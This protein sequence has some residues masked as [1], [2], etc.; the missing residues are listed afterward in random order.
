MD[1]DFYLYGYMYILC[2]GT[3]ASFSYDN[4]NNIRLYFDRIIYML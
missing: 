2:L 1:D 4:I 3:R